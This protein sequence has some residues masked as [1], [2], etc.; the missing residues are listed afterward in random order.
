LASRK[1]QPFC[2]ILCLRDILG[3][4]DDDS[5]VLTAKRAIPESKI[6]Q[7]ILQ[8]QKPQGCWEEPANPYHPKY[9][10]SYWQ[11]M[12]LDQFGMDKAKG[13]MRRACEHIFQFQLVEGGFSS[14]PLILH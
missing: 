13:E 4:S 5:D 11:I 14:C 6:V 1:N 2:S 7:R 9:R 3:K 12:T 8:K 10:S